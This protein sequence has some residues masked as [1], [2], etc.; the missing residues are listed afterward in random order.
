MSFNTYLNSLFNSFTYVSFFDNEEGN[1]PLEA[2]EGDQGNSDG[3]GEGGVEGEDPSNFFTQDDVNRF[4]ADDRRKHQE[5]YKQLEGSY[6]KM[7]KEGS[8]HKEQRQKM[9]ADLEDL[10]KAFRTKEQQAEYDRKKQAERYKN[11]LS[12]ATESAIKWETMYKS[13]VVERSLQDAAV[14]ADAFNPGQIVSLLKPM[15]KMVEETDVEGIP[16]GSMT[17]KVDFQ[18]IDE[19]T[20]DRITT[21]RTPEEAVKRMRE[22]PTLYGNLFK[23]NV[24]SGIGTGSATGGV[25]SGKG[26]IDRT[27]LTPE[28][29][30]RL[31]EENPEVLGLRRKK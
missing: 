13:S 2:T 16:V 10:Q 29:Y 21:L 14:S 27:R 26:N 4:L 18:D 25:T 1:A 28:Q 8:L 12:G 19:K 20:G 7:L 23:S 9:L 31:R 11:E 5:R 6:T 22:L 17:P 24:V 15:T 30:R 3:G